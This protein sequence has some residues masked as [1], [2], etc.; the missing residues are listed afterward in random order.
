MKVGIIKVCFICL[1]M[2]VIGQLATHIGYAKIDPKTIIG[3][4]LLDEGQ[5]EV[6]KD[7]SGKGNNGIVV[8]AEWVEGKFG[9]AL[10]FDGSS[11]V[12]IPATANTDNYVEGFT[13]LLWVK[14][15][16]A[17]G[18]NTRVIERDWHNPT[19]QIEASNFYGSIVIGG[20]E[21][22]SNVRGGTWVQ[23]E[24]SFVALT[25]NGSTLSLYVNDKMVADKK[26]GKPDLTKNN[27]GGSIWLAK[28][29]AGAGW[30]YKGVIDEVAV[31]SAALSAD[32]LKS[33]MNN[34]LDKYSAVSS[35]DKLTSTWGQ[36]K[37]EG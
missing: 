32:D 23:G 30:D 35:L 34:G 9:K 33:I 28:W 22:G 31:F 15:T 17:Q 13:Y 29:K 26:V 14:P 11:H 24:W 4:W 25:W 5:G 16:A 2:L 36:V 27:S 6:A 3:M 37:E 18:G 1:T 8:G 19:I 20:V 10:A 21:A 7:T 12:E